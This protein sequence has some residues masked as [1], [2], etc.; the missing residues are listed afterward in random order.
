VLQGRD[1]V[2][3]VKTGQGR[4]Y[5][6]HVKEIVLSQQPLETDGAHPLSDGEKELDPVS[7]E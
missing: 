3:E 1:A 6:R 7:E 4:T 2:V 5:R